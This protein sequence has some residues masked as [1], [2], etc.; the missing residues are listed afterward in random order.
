MSAEPTSA[1]PPFV[2]VHGGRHGGWCWKHVATAL[3]QAGHTVHTPTLTGLGE[4]SHLL[5]QTIGLG[6][7][8]QDIVA[9][10]E[11]EDIH[12]AVLVAHS[13]G[14]MVVAG[15]LEQIGDRVRRVV[16]LDAHL[17]GPGSPP[18]TSSAPTAPPTIWRTPRTTGKA[19]TSHRPTP[20]ATASP[21]RTTPHGSTAASRP[22]R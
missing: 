9:T 22:S 13:Y 8:V 7:H 4:R 20:P 11:F 1:R 18:S 21:T 16:Y 19:G 15:A 14:G 5:D 17:P 6:H 12:D 2:L 10:F 3:R